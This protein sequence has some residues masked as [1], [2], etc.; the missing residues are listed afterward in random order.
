MGIFGKDFKRAATGFATGGLSE[1]GGLLGGGGGGGVP[2]RSPQEQ[3]ILNL[4]LEALTGAEAE[5]AEFA[6]FVLEELGFGRTPEGDL[7]RM[8]RPGDELQG[9]L[10]ERALEGARGEVSPAVAADIAAD[11]ERQE[12][13][14]RRQFGPGFRASTGGLEQENRFNRQANIIREEA[15]RAG[16]GQAVGL[17]GQRQ[18][19]LSGLMQQRLGN[20][21]GVSAPRFGLLSAAAGAQQPFQFERSLQFQAGQQEAA[22]KARLTSD[23][24]GLLGLGIGAFA[25]GPVGA[26]VGSTAGRQIG[27]SLAG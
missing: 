7:V 3:A 22:D 6:P 10:L 14:L 8:D 27:G 26:G 24:G 17:L 16:L 1:L 13:A 23:I 21:Q 2:G 4:Q 15:R 12:E 9:L 19:L 11:R 18:G 25:G 5:R 20:L